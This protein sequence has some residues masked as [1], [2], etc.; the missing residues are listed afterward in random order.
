MVAESLPVGEDRQVKLA[1][2]T[3]GCVSQNPPWV[4]I[5]L[6]CHRFFAPPTA[7]ICAVEGIKPNSKD[8]RP[9]FSVE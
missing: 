4:N 9:R 7:T 8:L 5:G 3:A 2:S 1:I 6:N